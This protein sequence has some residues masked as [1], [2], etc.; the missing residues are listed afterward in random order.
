MADSIGLH[1]C[2]MVDRMKHYRVS[3]LSGVESLA[4]WWPPSVVY[5]E[6][7]LCSD[8]LAMNLMVCWCRHAAYAHGVTCLQF[9][10]ISEQ[11]LQLGGQAL[12]SAVA[13]RLGAR[14]AT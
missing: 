8:S 2:S 3:L 14:E 12:T 9:Y 4:C 1:T 5:C 7:V 10:K 6:V 11:E 13:C